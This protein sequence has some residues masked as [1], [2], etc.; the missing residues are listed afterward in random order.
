MPSVYDCWVKDMVF[1]EKK[2]LMFYEDFFSKQKKNKMLF[3]TVTQ[4][5]LLFHIFCDYRLSEVWT[6]SCWLLSDCFLLLFL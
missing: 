3:N 4:T 1:G 2:K 5:V 6:I